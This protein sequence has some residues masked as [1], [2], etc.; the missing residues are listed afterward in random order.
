MFERRVQAR[1]D[2][3]AEYPPGEAMMVLQ[4]D[5]TGRRWKLRL[6]T[7]ISAGASRVEIA[8]KATRTR[9]LSHFLFILYISAY[10]AYSAVVYSGRHPQRKCPA[11]EPGFYESQI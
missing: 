1:F 10:F 6:P 5:L 2:S 9:S 11:V 4:L 3:I 8:K 7:G